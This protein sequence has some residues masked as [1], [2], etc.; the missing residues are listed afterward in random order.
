M[1]RARLN[2]VLQL[3][4]LAVELVNCSIELQE[5]WN[6]VNHGCKKKKNSCSPS[7]MNLLSSRL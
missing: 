6:M 5:L 1:E 2:M 3:N 7:R 4:S